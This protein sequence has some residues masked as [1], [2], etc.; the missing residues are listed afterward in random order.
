MSSRPVYLEW[1]GKYFPKWLLRKILET[2]F[3]EKN[4]TAGTNSFAIHFNPFVRN[5]PFLP[6]ENIRKPYSF[7]TFSGGRE[8]VYWERMV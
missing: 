6:S 7:L 2:E 4:K 8:R 5:A 1:L 3:L